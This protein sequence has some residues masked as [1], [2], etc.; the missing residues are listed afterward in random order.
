M[1]KILLTFVLFLISFN[2]RA[3]IIVCEKMKGSL[4]NI[5]NK[6]VNV[7]F[8]VDNET[9]IWG[10]EENKITLITKY[11]HQEFLKLEDND[12][13]VRGVNN[14]NGIFIISY[15]KKNKI[16]FYSKQG[17]F[18]AQYHAKCKELKN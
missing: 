14:A 7:E 17:L 15:D 6:F 4:L 1:K 10:K 16:I 9:L 8:D 11:E 13:Y 5:Q 12:D 3:N 18:L 2:S